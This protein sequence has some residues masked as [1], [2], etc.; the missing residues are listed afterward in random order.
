MMEVIFLLGALS[1][2][3]ER[4]IDIVMRAVPLLKDVRLKDINIQMCLAWAFAIILLGS[5][6]LDIFKEL[7]GMELQ[8][9]MGIF[10]GAI[11]LSGGSNVIYDLIQLTKEKPK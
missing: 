5:L 6:Q 1:F 7:F 10:F 2:I 4:S 8:A 3:I 11:L 9:G